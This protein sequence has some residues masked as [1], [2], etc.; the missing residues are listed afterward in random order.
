MSLVR[1]PMLTRTR[2]ALVAAFATL[3]SAPLAGADTTTFEC[4]YKTYGDDKGLHK[5]GTPF[6][7]TFLVDSSSKKAYI[8]G[9]VGSS[10]VSSVPNAEGIT[11]VEI[12][13][14]GNVMT[15]VIT[16]KGKSVHSRGSIVFGDLVPSQYYGS[17]LKK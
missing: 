7:L 8:I 9:N 15:T 5:V 17:C 4:D 6:R 13:S 14:S 3:G 1:T 12:T 16:A 2:V 10:E 11:L